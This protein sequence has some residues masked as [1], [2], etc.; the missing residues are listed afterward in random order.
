MRNGGWPAL[1]GFETGDLLQLSG[2]I[3]F[4]SADPKSLPSLK[5]DLCGGSTRLRVSGCAARS[6]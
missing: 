2:T 5:P 3:E 4:A 1:C 6:H